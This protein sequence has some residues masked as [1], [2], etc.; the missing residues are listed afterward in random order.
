MDDDMQDLAAATRSEGIR[1]RH[2]RMANGEVRFR[3]L[4]GDGS[5]YIRTIAGRDGAWQNSHYHKSVVETYIVQRGWAA[6]VELAGDQPVWHILRSGDVFTTKP[7]VSHNIYMPPGSALH[8][9]KHGS[10]EQ[11]DWHPCPKLDVLTKSLSEP[12]IL[13]QG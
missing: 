1:T 11:D 6:L 10:G 7:N 2:E 13:S 3:L 8:T 5:A 9:V 12:E 4:A